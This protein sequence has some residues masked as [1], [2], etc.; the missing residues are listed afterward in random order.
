MSRAAFGRRKGASGRGGQTQVPS[1]QGWLWDEPPDGVAVIAA[2]H[3]RRS[4]PALM[5]YAFAQVDE[6]LLVIDDGRRIAH[7]NAMAVRLLGM[8]QG[9]RVPRLADVSDPALQ[10][11]CRS[12]DAALHGGRVHGLTL[13]LAGGG[14]EPRP[15]VLQCQPLRDDADRV[16]GARC[17]LR[18]LPGHAGGNGGEALQVESARLVHDFNN[19]LTVL[20]ASLSLAAEDVRGPAAELVLAAQE[21]TF[22]AKALTLDLPRR[23]ARAA[24]D[25]GQLPQAVGGGP[26]PPDGLRISPAVLSTLHAIEP[27]LALRLVLRTGQ[28]VSRLVVPGALVSVRSGTAARRG[29]EV[30]VVVSWR[31]GWAVRDDGV[32][33]ALGRLRRLLGDQGGRVDAA[34]RGGS[35]ELRLCLPLAARLQPSAGGMRILLMDDDA[36]VRK[37]AARILHDAQYEVAEVPDGQAAI[38]LF[39]EAAGA[40]R[41]FD[42]AL[43]DLNVPGGMG[44]EE[45]GRHLLELD[46]ALPI[47]ISTGRL[48]GMSPGDYLRLGFR[49][50][51]PKPYTAAELRAGVQLA[52][53]GNRSSA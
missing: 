29:G 22:A 52:L 12:V 25:P 19:V 37:T 11:V 27:R 34:L 16:C 14:V 40:C 6:G 13:E 28:A 30:E 35:A 48:H 33:G 46:P 23:L 51:V 17:S 26:R 10:A 1:G 21:A 42:L 32:A 20:L 31:G 4:G 38:A 50:V 43:L 41:P 49:G 44:G 24:A 45:V 7:V 47:L 9:A 53:Q 15:Y 18:E 39:R 36:K 5:R 3:D 8:G 2:A